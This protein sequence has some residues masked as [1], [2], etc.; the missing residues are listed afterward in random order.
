M[1]VVVVCLRPAGGVCRRLLTQHCS[2]IP[3]HSLM[4][5]T[6]GRVRWRAGVGAGARVGPTGAVGMT[7]RASSG[8]TLP[9]LVGTSLAR[10]PIGSVLIPPGQPSL[11]PARLQFHPFALIESSDSLTRVILTKYLAQ[12]LPRFRAP[13]RDAIHPAPPSFFPAG[14]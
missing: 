2:L 3:A 14:L 7:S 4:G 1:L 12:H 8:A 5:L 10:A 6:N 11:V 9:T 13:A